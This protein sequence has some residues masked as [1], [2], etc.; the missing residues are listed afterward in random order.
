MQF[1][2]MIDIA[3]PEE[4][5]KG[6]LHS[7][8]GRKSDTCNTERDMTFRKVDL[9]FL[10]QERWVMPLHSQGSPGNP[11]TSLLSWLS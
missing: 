10:K 2:K 6:C 11:Q 4:E 3:Q 9:F 8:Q 1:V 5:G 7:R